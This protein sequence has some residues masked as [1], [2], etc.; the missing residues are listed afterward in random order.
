MQIDHHTPTG[1]LP[2]TRPAGWLMKDDQSL[3]A[4]RLLPGEVGGG[5]ERG[6]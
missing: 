2:T 6:T 3:G 5:K 4:T 1:W